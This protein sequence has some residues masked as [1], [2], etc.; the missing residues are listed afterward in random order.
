MTLTEA[1]LRPLQRLVILAFA[2]MILRGLLPPNGFSATVLLFDYEFGLIRRG[3]M[4]SL[5]NLYWGDE[6]TRGEVFA[7]SAVMSLFGLLALFVHVARVWLRD[8]AGALLALVLFTS[9]AFGAI[10]AAVGY[11]DLVIIGLVCLSLLT[12]PTR[13]AGAVAR[14]A[15]LVLGMAFHEVALGY[16]MVFL[17]AEIWVRG[18][19]L[20]RALLPIIA[21]V[22]A[23]AV[24]STAADLP[25]EDIPA[26]MAHIDAKAAFTPDPEAT[27]VVERRLIDNLAVMAEKRTE[28]GYRAWVVFDGVPL[29]AMMLWCAWL[30]LRGIGPGDPVARVLALGAIAAPLSLNV[31]AFDVVRFGAMSVLCAMLLA[32]ALW[33]RPEA[34][35]RM[36]SALSLPMVLT[37]IVLN[38]MFAVTQIGEGEGHVWAL[39]WVFLKQ[40]SWF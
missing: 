22:A 39:P 4:G 12:D 19:G 8:V 13:W 35:A 36:Q 40:L 1:H 14:A 34:R 18:G 15:A 3:L 26:F 33:T 31:I 6:V 27:V 9:F 20:A 37:V 30:V 7:V 29:L 21:G 38:L 16:V 23:F 17:A 32:V 2:L 25:A 10:V 24:L 11:M 28:A 5:A